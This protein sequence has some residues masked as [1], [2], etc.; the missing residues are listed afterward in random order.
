MGRDN[1]HPIIISNAAI[2]DNDLKS[3]F[4]KLTSPCVSVC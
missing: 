3:I 1:V 2:I 4:Y